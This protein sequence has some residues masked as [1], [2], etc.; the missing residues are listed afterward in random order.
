MKYWSGAIKD[1]LIRELKSWK[2]P[3][4]MKTKWN[5]ADEKKNAS[6]VCHAY[7]HHGGNHGQCY[8]DQG[9]EVDIASLPKTDRDSWYWL[10]ENMPSI[11]LNPPQLLDLSRLGGP[12][13][14]DD[15]A[16]LPPKYPEPEPLEEVPCI[17]IHDE[18]N[19]DEALR[20][21]DFDSDSDEDVSKPL[22][23]R[24]LET[25]LKMLEKYSQMQVH[26]G[27]WEFYDM[28]GDM[29]PECEIEEA[30]NRLIAEKEAKELWDRCEKAKKEK[31][32]GKQK[33]MTKP[34]TKRKIQLVADW[35]DNPPEWLEQVKEEEAMMKQ[36]GLKELK[37][38]RKERGI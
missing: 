20:A 24:Q 22:R 15:Y 33:A 21:A 27:Y 30:V 7:H 28:C 34:E 13:I 25:K 29:L 10:E 38:Y 1:A 5:N 3:V 23:E 8:L 26:S 9:M 17:N 11:Q 37:E 19:N 36:M 12:S 16:P 6:G 32:E 14:Y 18:E 4:L 35:D 31:L 2:K